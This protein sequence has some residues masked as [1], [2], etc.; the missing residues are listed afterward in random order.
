MRPNVLKVMFEVEA[1]KTDNLRFTVPRKAVKALGLKDDDRI[2]LEIWSH[3]GLTT[4]VYKM[5]SGTEVYVTKKS[6]K[7]LRKVVN[8]GE[9]LLVT[10]S[11]P[12]E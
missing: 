9:R 1:S 2:R 7:G 11:R 10:A 4:D 5:A 3:A 12:A 8:M 6:N